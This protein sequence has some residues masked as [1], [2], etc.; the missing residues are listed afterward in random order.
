M[1]HVQPVVNCKISIYLK[2]LHI[3]CEQ[4]NRERLQSADDKM[5]RCLIAS[6]VRFVTP[7]KKTK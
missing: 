1:G 6:Y 2:V 5:T 7:D 3:C 4:K